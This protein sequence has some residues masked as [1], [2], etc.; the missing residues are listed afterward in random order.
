MDKDKLKEILD[1]HRKWYMGDNDGKHADLRSADLR[2]ADLRSADLSGADLSGANLRSADLSGADLSGADLRS[3]NLSGADLRSADLRSADL[4][5]AYLRSAD[6]RSAD[7]RSADLRRAN[8]MRADLSSANLGGAELSGADLSGA[9]LRSADLSGAYLRSADLRSANLSGAD[10]SGADLRSANLTD[11]LLSNID[12]LPYIGIVPDSKGKARAY[13]VINTLG[14]GCFQGGINY[15]NNKTSTVEDW[16]NDITVH[17]SKGV[18]LATFQ[19]CLNNKQDKTNRLLL[20]EFDV[21]P[22]NVCVPLGSDGK[23]RVKTAMRIG[24]CD[25]TGRLIKEIKIGEIKDGRTDSQ[26]LPDKR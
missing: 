6:L 3:A 5:G 4:S 12:W 16:D 2:S 1:K 26:A 7:L 11:T 24:E 21:S 20:M 23:F 8:L 13:K 19:W 15:L 9:D 22:E 18:N 14:E 17:C 10:L 25:W